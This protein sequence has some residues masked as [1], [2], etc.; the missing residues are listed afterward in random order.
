MNKKALKIC[1]TCFASFLIL[2]FVF[3]PREPVRL[4]TGHNKIIIG[5]DIDAYLAMREGQFDD[6]IDGV[7]KQVIWAGEANVKTPISIIYLHGL[8]RQFK[9]NPAGAGSGGRRFGRQSLFYSLYRSWP[10]A[11]STGRCRC[12]ALD[13]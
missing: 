5:N 1:L 13:G 11:F 4:G 2:V 9:R 8:Y 3:G 7:E 12:W 10:P 6:I